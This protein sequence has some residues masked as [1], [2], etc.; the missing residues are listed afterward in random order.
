MTDHTLGLLLIGVIVV[1][2]LLACADSEQP[3]PIW[4][5]A[6]VTRV[7]FALAVL[8]LWITAIARLV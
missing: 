2:V 1:N 4:N 5:P 6:H 7:G 8:P 3:K